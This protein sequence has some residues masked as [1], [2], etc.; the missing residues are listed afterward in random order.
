MG[1]EQ[2]A[3]G[4]L[5]LIAAGQDQ[6]EVVVT[7]M[8]GFAPGDLDD[9]AGAGV[10]PEVAARESGRGNSVAANQAAIALLF[11]R[12]HDVGRALQA[13][14][15][16]AWSGKAENAEAAQAAFLHRARMNGLASTGEWSRSLEKA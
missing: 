2:G 3:P 12:Q 10:E 11:G 13:A 15:Q 7:G 9:L 1:G 6:M 16:T 4:G 14:P 5:A 8:I